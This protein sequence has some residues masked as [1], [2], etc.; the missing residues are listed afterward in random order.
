MMRGAGDGVRPLLRRL[1]WFPAL[2]AGI[3]LVLA[4][5]FAIDRRWFFCGANLIL[6]LLFAVATWLEHEAQ[7]GLG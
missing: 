4:I 6:A 2:A 5:Y 1:W 3:Y 7:K